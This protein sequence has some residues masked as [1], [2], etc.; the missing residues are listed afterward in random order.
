MKYLF[1][2]TEL[3]AQ[4]LK[5]L[6]EVYAETTQDFILDVVNYRPQLALDLGCGPVYTTHFLAKLTGCRQDVGLDNSIHFISLAEQS[7]TDKVTFY[8]HDI[9]SLPFPLGTSDFLYCRFLLTHLKDPFYII[10]K[11]ASQLQAKGFLLIEEVEWIHT[12]NDIFTIYLDIVEGMLVDQS[13]QLYI[14]PT[15]NSLERTDLLKKRSSQ[16]RRLSV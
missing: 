4:R 5:Y 7:K 11:W 6:A 10:K 16:V 12:K 3:A 15:L 2:D 9:T 8:L 1:T 14:G 13:N